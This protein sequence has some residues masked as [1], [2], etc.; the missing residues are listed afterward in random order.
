MTTTTRI[1]RELPGILGDLSAGPTPDYLDDVFGRTGRMRQRPGWT[2]PERWLPMADISRARTFAPAPPW[3]VVALALVVIAVV[4][5]AALVYIGSQRRVPAPF[6]PARNGL[7]PYVSAGDIYVGDP[8]TGATRLLVGGP[9]DDAAPGFSPDGTRL[10]FIRDVGR[11]IGTI[12]APVHLFVVR[13]DGTG[14]T[15]LT[16]KPIPKLVW[17]AWT[18]DGRQLAVVQPFHGVNQLDLFDADGPKPPHRIA[19][20]TGIDSVA[21]RPPDGRQILFRALVDGRYGLYTMNAD[22]T[23]H[24]TL[25]EPTETAEYDQE[26]NAAIY[27]A[28]G[29]RIFYQRWTPDSIQ[30][31]VMNADGTDP[32]EFVSEPG[33]G[34]DGIADPSPDGRWIAYWHVIEDGRSTQRVSVVRADGTGPVIPIGPEMTGTARWVW[35]PDS[36]KILMMPD[37]GGNG[38]AYLL[39]PAGGPWTSVPWTSDLDMDWQRLAG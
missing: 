27:S 14:L 7:I 35:A 26:L 15:R 12:P 31:W 39:D 8:V 1:E 36:T 24:Q 20:A 3:R 19:V 33:Q 23:N 10:A 9:E 30:L 16:T 37:E 11:A 32:H 38:S 2:F 21:F 25:V 4:T 5:A 28:D 34:W 6:G 29:T 13:D 18:P 17:A 22:G